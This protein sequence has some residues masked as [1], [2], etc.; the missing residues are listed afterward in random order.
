MELHFGARQS[1]LHTV[2]KMVARITARHR[3]IPATTTRFPARGV[4]VAG[5][6][7]R[8]GGGSSSKKN[9]KKFFS[10]VKK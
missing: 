5:G 6:G 9:K 10:D 1:F 8:G 2:I 7:V 4:L 3:E